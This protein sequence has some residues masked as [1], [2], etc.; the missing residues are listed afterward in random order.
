MNLR[1]INADNRSIDKSKVHEFQKYFMRFL[2]ANG[3]IIEVGV[4]EGRGKYMVPNEEMRDLL[5]S[6]IKSFLGTVYGIEYSVSKKERIY[7]TK[8]I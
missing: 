3:C 7:K 6:K 8:Y 5:C 1:E 2:L 4:D